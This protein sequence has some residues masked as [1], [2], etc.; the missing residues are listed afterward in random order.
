[1]DTAGN[2]SAQKALQDVGY[3]D[4]AKAMNAAYNQDIQ[5]KIQQQ[6]AETNRLNVTNN[7]SEAAARIAIAKAVEGSAVVASVDESKVP[8]AVQLAYAPV[9][10]EMDVIAGAI[11]KAQADGSWNAEGAGAKELIARQSLLSKRAL[12]MLSPYMGASKGETG[13]DPLGFNSKESSGAP[14]TLT[15]ENSGGQGRSSDA[16]TRN[17]LLQEMEVAVKANDKKAIA[18]IT[19]DLERLDVAGAN[20]TKPAENVAT[21]SAAPAHGKPQEKGLITTSMG[22]VGNYL[23]GMGVDYSTPQ[24]KAA[25]QQRVIEASKGGAPLTRIERMRAEQAGFIK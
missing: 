7:A 21:A 25:L 23:S 18:Q 6:N 10:K 3:L 24:G 4:E 17:T 12:K 13:K 9:Q 1:L 14:E 5:T 20:K 11:A 15:E 16:S 8:K 22:D 2:I 19:K